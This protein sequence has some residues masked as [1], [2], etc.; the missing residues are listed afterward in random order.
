MRNV[1]ALFRHVRQRATMLISFIVDAVCYL[2]LCLRPNPALA[3]ENL[4]LRQQL[5]L[6]E[7]RQVKPRRA[8]NAMRLAMVWLSSWFDWRLA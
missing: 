4:F 5:A 7:E 3:A 1:S 6:Y 8:T 2:G